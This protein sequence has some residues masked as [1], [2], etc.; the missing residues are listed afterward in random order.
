MTPTSK[1]PFRAPA[2]EA[3]KAPIPARRKPLRFSTAPQVIPPREPRNGNATLSTS[4]KP[5]SV[6]N[7]IPCEASA[8]KAKG[9]LA[10]AAEGNSGSDLPA[11]GFRKTESRHRGPRTEDVKLGPTTISPKAKSVAKLVKMNA[12]PVEETPRKVKNHHRAHVVGKDGKLAPDPPAKASQPIAIEVKKAAGLRISSSCTAEGD[13]HGKSLPVWSNAAPQPIY[14]QSNADRSPRPDPLKRDRLS[15]QDRSSRQPPSNYPVMRHGS[16]SPIPTITAARTVSE[17]S[18]KCAPEGPCSS[19]SERSPKQDRLSFQP[20]PKLD[21][22]HPGKDSPIRSNAVA[23]SVQSNASISKAPPSAKRDRLP[24]QNRLFSPPAPK[25]DEMRHVKDPPVRRNS[26]VQMTLAESTPG[27]SSRSDPP[28]QAGPSCQPGPKFQKTPPQLELTGRITTVPVD[29]ATK[30]DDRRPASIKQKLED[31][32]ERGLKILQMSEI[33]V[34]RAERDAYVK[35]YR[36]AEGERKFLVRHVQGVGMSAARATASLDPAQ[37]QEDLESCLDAAIAEDVAAS[38]R[39]SSVIDDLR[40]KLEQAS[41]QIYILT[42]KLAQAASLQRRDAA[43]IAEQGS[44]IKGLTRLLAA[45]QA[46]VV[47]LKCK[48]MHPAGQEP[49]LQPQDSG[50]DVYNSASEISL[51]TD[52]AFTRNSCSI[53]TSTTTIAD[54]TKWATSIA[55]VEDTSF[56]V[57][58]SAAPSN[59]LFIAETVPEGKADV[60]FPVTNN[61][62]MRSTFTAPRA[63]HSMC[64]GGNRLLTGGDG[65]GVQIFELDHDAL[66]EKGK[67]LA[68]VDP[69]PLIPSNS[70]API[71]PPQKL[72]GSLRVQSLDFSPRLMT[73]AGSKEFLATV[74]RTLYCCDLDTMKVTATE[75]VGTD[76]LLTASWSPHMGSQ[77]ICTGGVDRSINVIDARLFGGTSASI[78]KTLDGHQSA[79]TALEFNPFIPYLMASA[80]EDA[81][82]KMWDLRYL[83]HC[84]GRID[85]HYQGIHSLAW[86]NSHAE[87]LTT[88]SS[89]RSWRA[90][91]FMSGADTVRTTTPDV[92]V[93]CPGS[94]WGRALY[95]EA[96]AEVSVGAQMIGE[97][98][99]YTSPVIKVVSSKQLL[100]TYY[101]VS[102]IGQVC[103][104]TLPGEAF[105]PILPHF[106]DSLRYPAEHEV[107]ESIH[108]RNLPPAISDVVA[109]CRTARQEGQLIAPNEVELLKLCTP[110]PPADPASWNIPVPSMIERVV[111]TDAVDKVREELDE[112]TYFLPPGF[113]SISTA[114]ELIKPKLRNDLSMAISRCKLIT[115]V[116]DGSW[117][118]VIRDEKLICKGMEQDTYF[119]NGATLRFIVQA[120]LQQ[121]YI[122]GLSLGLKLTSIIADTPQRPF[123][124]TAEVFGVLLF[125][126]V[127]DDA[128]TFPPSDPLTADRRKATVAE[129]VTQLMAQDKE[130]VAR[131]AHAAARTKPKED[132]TAAKKGHARSLST[133]E[134]GAAFGGLV[135][136]SDSKAQALRKLT[137][138]SDSILP[139]LR[140]ETRIAKTL[141]G[142]KSEAETHADVLRI[143][144]TVEDQDTAEGETKHKRP[145]AE[146]TISVYAIRA[147]LDALL[148]HR[149]FVEYYTTCFDLVALYVTHDIGNALLDHCIA[150]ATAKFDTHINGLYELATAKL[151]EALDQSNTS[152]EPLEEVLLGAIEKLKEGLVTIVQCGALLSKLGMADK[153]RAETIRGS[154]SHLFGVL[155]TSLLRALDLVDRVLGAGGV[156]GAAQSAQS[157]LR[158]TVLMSTTTAAQRR[159]GQPVISTGPNPSS[160]FLAEVN[161]LVEALGKVGR[162]TEPI[163]R[164]E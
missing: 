103:C 61:L 43:K 159:F 68:H 72:T 117:E 119:I 52:C 115:E 164:F 104:H 23:T 48:T 136:G 97:S 123:T 124:D 130:R 45:S 155:R 82:V 7:P 102:A 121:D 126:T 112:W 39:Y 34:L 66:G 90:W 6:K 149:R 101:T 131:L 40:A 86:S 158:D 1:P 47:S 31:T 65:G 74:G 9:G 30:I 58:G 60:E 35:A 105:E 161:A 79:V 51:T 160:E 83:Q 32:Y 132:A 63:I 108:T 4:A 13:G 54:S 62:I 143:F 17:E 73:D 18:T 110:L 57:V 163:S 80:G 26:L 11:T 153:E 91:A 64:V 128:S 125:P 49:C 122:K 129:H 114:M 10:T 148:A 133:T 89:D 50:I 42:E 78:W 88:A 70:K 151:A 59:N 69:F 120:V 152:P 41:E 139:M 96:K 146:K 100:D 67:G 81:V 28:Q 144:D 16:D 140:L 44:A 118:A 21:E 162:M 134:T 106:Y 145:F 2:S 22:M 15:K 77:L 3:L 99:E 19:K 92:F 137:E 111:N 84:V 36:Q 156:R 24:K 93:S 8:Q 157:A 113:E 135:T 150:C 107:E 109:I 87:T 46:S 71:S 85:A 75:S 27:A 20:A 138:T 5:K 12:G 29:V 33:E 141:I 154:F 55:V 95:A 25:A 37:L 142:G 38:A 76:A 147:Y 116:L 53:E 14:V 94:E 98:R 127:F 56:L